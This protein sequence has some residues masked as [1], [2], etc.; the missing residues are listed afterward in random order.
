MSGLLDKTETVHLA[1][2]PKSL[3]LHARNNIGFILFTLSLLA[4]NAGFLHQLMKF[5][6]KNEFSSH[7]LLIPFISGWLLLKNRQWLNRN[8]NGR[9]L[10]SII[11]AIGIVLAL[12]AMANRSLVEQDYLALRAFA[13]LMILLGGFL[14]FYGVAGFRAVIFPL[15]FLFFMVPI[16]TELYRE[17]VALLQ[18]GTAEMSAKLFSLTGTPYLR[19]ATFFVLPSLSINIAPQ[20]SGIR[21]SLALLITMMLAAYLMLKTTWKRALLV[22]LAIPLAMFKN[23][24][25]IVALSLLAIHIDTRILTNSTLHNDG[26]ILFFL[27]ALLIMMPLLLILRKSESNRISKTGDSTT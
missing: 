27:L 12:Y 1:S 17:I 3:W 4:V 16:P 10:G 6:L 11:A 21:S 20:C 26:G 14:I 15:L 25:R 24:I 8:A 2:A 18:Q 7:I 9:Y 23:A 13:L 19:E 5:S 22:L